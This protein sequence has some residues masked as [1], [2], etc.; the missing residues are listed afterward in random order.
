M[1]TVF[2][3]FRGRLGGKPAVESQPEAR[4]THRAAFAIDHHRRPRVIPE[5]EGLAIVKYGLSTYRHR[6]S[7]YA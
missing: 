7:S 6:C 4:L 3:A 1:N 5:N 2:S